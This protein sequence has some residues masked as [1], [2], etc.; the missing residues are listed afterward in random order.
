LTDLIDILLEAGRSALDVSLY[1]LLPIMVVMMIAMRLLEASG[2]LD[3]IIRLAGPVLKPFGLNGLG[4]LAMLQIGLVSFIA[5]VTTLVLMDDRGEPDRRL[6]ATF[7]AVMGMAPANAVFPLAAMGLHVGN[8][9]LLSLGGGLAAAAATYWILGRKLST[10]PEPAK[11]DAQAA[12]G[13]PGLLKIINGSGREAIDIV[14]NIIPMLILSLA[15]VAGL[16]RIG[17]V[18]ALVGGLAPVLASW[19][20]PTSLVV[21]A[22]TKLLA[23]S[24]ALVGVVHQMGA[25]HQID[26]AAINTGAA[27]LLHPID[28]PGVAIFA[29][30]SIRLGRCAVPAVLG[31]CVG[32]LARCLAAGLIG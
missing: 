13:R 15:V 19:D 14:I 18:D 4:A 30:A 7:A 3:W 16:R 2:I 26:A 22:V 5:P 1:T 32:I 8:M 31:G 6:A 10:A 9:M 20:V 21:P 29:S 11:A 23:G 24:T 28:L 27:A 25:S 17:A 12:E